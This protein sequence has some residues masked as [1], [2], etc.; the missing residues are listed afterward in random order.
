ME[1]NWKS[2]DGAVQLFLGDCLE[3]L[4]TLEAGS[5]DAVITDPPYGIDYDNAGGFSEDCGWRKFEKLGWDKVRPAK[6]CFDELLR[7]SKTQIV[8]GGNYFTDMLPPTMQWLVWDKGQRDFTLADCEFAWSSQYRA[9]RIL[10]L[11][12]A[13]A[14]RE[15]RHH[16]TQKPLP[17]IEWCIGLVK[18]TPQTIL[19]AFLGGGTTGVACIRLGRK[20]IGI[21][22][23]EKYFEIAK[24]RIIGAIAEEKSNLFRNQIAA[25]REQEKQLSLLEGES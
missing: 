1:P 21:E 2:D 5:I 3:V 12:R 15:T 18:P 16:P 7:I 6:E 24:A 22:R 13:T 11:P 23:E 9:A 14:N 17:L 25:E 10:D 20:F 19:D 4:P 8:W